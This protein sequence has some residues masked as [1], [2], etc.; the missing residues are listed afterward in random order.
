MSEAF[1]GL[2]VSF[3]QALAGRYSLERELGRGGMGIVYLAREVRLDRLVA[4]KLLPPTL[5]A[6]GSLRARFLREARTAAR[7]SQPNIIQIFAVDEIGEF[8]FYV[9]AF[10][11]GETL[12]HRVARIGPL[13]P[14]EAARILREVAWALAYAHAQGVVHRDVKPENILLERDTGRAMVAD[15]GIARVARA[16]SDSGAGEILGTPEYMSPEQAAGESVDGRSDLYSLGA[17]GYYALTGRAPFVGTTASSVMAQHLTKPAPALMAVAPAVP[18]PLAQALDRCLAKP[19]DDRFAT[20]EAFADALGDTLEIR[21][22]TPV[23]VRSF[24]NRARGTI[25]L[26]AGFYLGI[27]PA[28]V[29]HL[30][31]LLAA[32]AAWTSYPSVFLLVAI[33]TVAL[34]PPGY[35]TIQIRRL[36]A[37]GYGPEDIAQGLRLTAER[38]REEYRFEHGPTLTLAERATRV[39]ALSALGTAVLSAGGLLT[40]ALPGFLWGI[41]AVA[42][43]VAVVGGLR[44][45]LGAWRR[46]P[47]GSFWGKVWGGPV[48][49]FLFRLAGLGVRR[50]PGVAPGRPTELA[51]AFAADALFE[52]LPRETRRA[53]G[54]VP[55]AVR[56]LERR[57]H[58]IRSRVDE[59][60]RTLAQAK[61]TAATPP[62]ARH[63]ALVADLEA[64]RD[65][66]QG[67]LAQVVAA[68]ETVRL[69]LL[70]LRAGAGSVESVTADLSAAREI[71]EQTEGLLQA[72]QQ[73][74]LAL[75]P[76]GGD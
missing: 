67:R 13:P 64:A 28:L 74:E 37:S 27:L 20:G 36:L 33:T 75:R 42:G 50:G 63:Q 58:E 61:P 40:G 51:I 68:L 48:G 55:E 6:H 12:G 44:W 53:L 2:F 66:A 41:P 62:D 1:D 65:T 23:P 39:L 73:V 49:R 43:Y 17:V 9:M 7:L 76:P 32:G 54:D 46:E 71:G 3:Q 16:S 18:R 30:S 15:F 56:R 52:E 31:N 70:R 10:V 57:A 8:V 14:P 29:S 59:I 25:P 60:N 47:R 5:A 11:D 19:P 21:R 26:L 35:L 24:V 72:R 4:I 22:E 45:A 38:R 34:V 69:D